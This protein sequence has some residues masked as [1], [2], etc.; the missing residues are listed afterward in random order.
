MKS[1]KT[2]DC[3][4]VAQSRSRKGAWI[5]IFLFPAV[6]YGIIVAPARERGLKCPQY[7]AVQQ[8]NIVAPARE[9]GL[10]LHRGRLPCHRQAGR[11]R[12]GAWIEIK[13]IVK[14]DW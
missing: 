10:K 8:L 12:K 1:D 2:A 5:E 13:E 7:S 6:L 14:N 3:N 4:R 11:S 9:R